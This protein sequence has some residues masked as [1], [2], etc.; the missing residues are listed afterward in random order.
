METAA[1][2]SQSKPIAGL[3]LEIRNEAAGRNSS[4]WLFFAGEGNIDTDPLRAV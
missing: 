1:K 4:V 3:W 2:Q